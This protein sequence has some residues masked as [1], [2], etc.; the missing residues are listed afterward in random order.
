MIHQGKALTT[1]PKLADGSARC[2]VT[3]PPY[4]GLRDYGVDGQMGLEPSP[5]CLGWASGDKCGECYVCKM[6]EVFAE[7]RRVLADD[8]TL[9]LNMGDCYAGSWG[10]QSRGTG[11]DPKN[12]HSLKGSGL[13]KGQ[14]L[15]APAK[16]PGRNPQS[17][18]R[19]RADAGG[20]RH[21]DGGGGLK[22]KD[23][24]GVPWRLALALQ[25]AGW[26]LR[27]DII[28]HKP[29]PMPESI[30]DRPTKAHEY[31][32]LL[33]KRRKY[34]YDADAIRER[35]AEDTSA[36]YDRAHAEYQAPGQAAHSGIVGFRPN[37][38]KDSRN[39]RSSADFRGHDMRNKDLERYGTTRGIVN[40]SCT[41]P[42]GRNK[43]TVWTLATMATPEA[44][45]ATFPIELA[46]TCI[47]AGSAPGDTILD[48]FAG[49]GTTGLAALKHGRA[50]VGIEIKPEYIAMAEERLN[51]L[52]PLLAE[53]AT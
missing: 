40:E 52:M 51:R 28:W 1:L 31:V 33:T 15:S 8:G 43:R 16:N 21:K 14:I 34:F 27:S 39:G 44:H 42:Q 23:L 45:F 7:V 26:W 53:A 18:R 3:S 32:F 30:T 10:A 9:W 41:H 24:I 47:L 50:F 11:S 25:A 35:Q 2:V 6:V 22:P 36:R 38:R 4:W 20:L 5:D 48:P 37:V 17:F 12:A 29:N 19:D 49:I 46:E 13:S